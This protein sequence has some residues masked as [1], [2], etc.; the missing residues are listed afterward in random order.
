MSR[1]PLIAPRELHAL[2]LEAP[3]AA[4]IDATWT[5]DGGPA[6]R[7]SGRIAHARAF[8]I[9]AI[10]D[11]ASELPHMLPAPEGF[12]AAMRALGVR[13]TDTV[14]VYDRMG[15]FSAPRVWWMFRAM[16]HDDVRVLDGGLPGWLEAGLPVIDAP[17]L[18]AA[19]E[20]SDYPAPAAPR[21]V[22]DLNAMRAHVEAGDAQI[23]DA[24]PGPRF[25]GLAP[26]PRPGLR[27]GAIPG[28]LNT[29]YAELLTP[30]GR[31]RPAGALETLFARQGVDLARPIVATCGSGVTAC[32]VALALARLDRA[33]AAVYDGSWAEWG[34]PDGPG[35]AQDTP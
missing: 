1:D 30:E 10:A 22:R 24:R 15:L 29:P 31:M 7:A 26:E 23:L 34:R 16:G 27:K 6:P 33:D 5:Y 25:A 13:E 19:P 11:Q 3:G 28:S 2:L 4:L 35:I 8:D 18:S 14:V 20:P 21:L 17:P 9:D 12:A 32:I